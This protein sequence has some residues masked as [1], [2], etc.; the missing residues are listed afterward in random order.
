[1]HA[2]TYWVGLGSNL[3]DRRAALQ[4][5]VD[6]LRAEGVDVDAV[7][8]VYETAP[9]LVTDQPAFLNAAVRVRTPL[10]PRAL[11]AVLKD[12]ERRHGREAGGVRYGPRPIDADILWWDG[13]AYR[14]DALVIPH[15]R[16]TERRFAMAGPLAVDPGLE[17]PDGTRLADAFAAIDPASQPVDEW[18]GGGASLH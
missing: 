3:G 5:A 10:G 6:A 9:Q 18:P 15:P 14:D 11:L 17:L 16:L 4:A 1:M 7:S 12:M 8:P 13:G 2:H